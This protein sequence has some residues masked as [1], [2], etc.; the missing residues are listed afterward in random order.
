MLR[1]PNGL[2]YA[3]M[4]LLG[5]DVLFDLVLAGDEVRT[6][7]DPEAAYE[8]TTV[9]GLDPVLTA[10]AAGIAYL[11]TVVVF[12]VWFHR[13][14][15]NS[16]VWALDIHSRTPGWAIGAWFIPFANLWIPRRIAVDVWRASR[17]D[18]YAADGA[19]ELTLLNSWWTCF[20][21]GAVVDRISSTLYKRAETLDAWTTAAAW[22][23]AGYLLTIAAGVLAILFVR[24]L[25]SMQHAK[26]TGMLSAA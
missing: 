21:A 9:A 16:D 4:A 23:L 3:V 14:R 5:V 15:K 6:L 13:V 10:L 24:R 8:A 17:P 7:V 1:N 2:A 20:A 12:L 26:A 11:A 25:T 19:R 22:S 18:P